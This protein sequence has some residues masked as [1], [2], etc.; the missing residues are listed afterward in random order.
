MP[1]TVQDLAW[2]LLGVLA[3]VVWF[4]VRREIKRTD[5]H[6]T[7]SEKRETAIRDLIGQIDNESMIRDDKMGQDIA[8][9]RQ[10]V[11]AEFVRQREI[12]GLREDLIGRVADL[13]NDINKQ[14]ETVIRLITK[15]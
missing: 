2:L 14:F 13:K 6:Q 5:S 15:P 9:L 3:T 8:T 1:S 11:D 12:H 7:D 10:Y 4:L